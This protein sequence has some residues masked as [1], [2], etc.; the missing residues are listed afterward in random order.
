MRS[1]DL[2]SYLPLQW[3][4]LKTWGMIRYSGTKNDN[5]GAND[6]TLLGAK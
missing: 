4:R 1:Q 5:A 2:V 6:E 3:S